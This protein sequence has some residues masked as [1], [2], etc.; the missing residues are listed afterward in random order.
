MLSTGPA[1]KVIIHLNEDTTARNDF[2]YAEIFNFL[3]ARGVAGATLIRPHASFGTHHQI[4]ISGAGLNEGEHLP[5]RIEFLEMAAV[6]ERLLP[7]LCTLVTDG[8]IE[9]HPTTI[10]KAAARRE[11]I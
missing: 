5:V 3:F 6:A 9:T 2:L 7:D 1:V 11:A 4:H 8:I 10:V